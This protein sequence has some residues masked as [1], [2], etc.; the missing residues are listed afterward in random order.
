MKHVIRYGEWEKPLNEH[1]L[2]R[3]EALHL[4]HKC[5]GCS[6]ESET[7]FHPLVDPINATDGLKFVSEMLQESM[8]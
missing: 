8:N 1:Q 4:A 5:E 2:A 3:V 6:N 7:V